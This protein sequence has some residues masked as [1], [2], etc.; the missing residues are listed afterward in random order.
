[1]KSYHELKKLYDGLKESYD[2]LKKPYE[3]LLSEME[4]EM[5]EIQR[6][7]LEAR[8]RKHF[9]EQQMV[10][11]D[12]TQIKSDEKVLFIDLGANL[13]QG[14]CWFKK[15][16]NT[17]NVSFELFEPNPN[18]VEKLRELDEV[19]SGEVT[20]HPVGV[21]AKEGLFDFFGLDDAEGGKHS[22]G[23]SIVQEHNSD[24]YNSSTDKSIRVRIINFSSYLAEKS[25]K[26]D[27]IICKMD[28]EGA[29]VELLESLLKEKTADLISVLYVEFHSQY[30]SEAHA[31]VTRQREDKILRALSEETSTLVRIWH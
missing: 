8:T 17:P 25:A 29:E 26:Y 21:G 18:C 2:Q 14:Y 7:M 3:K 4:A 19:K 10:L 13:G 28:I 27:R 24:R 30:Q 16:F 31:Q 20:L 12:S 23:G 6:Q 22:Q 11:Q 15:F 5:E 9:E 1:M